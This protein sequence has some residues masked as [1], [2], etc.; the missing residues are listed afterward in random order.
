M[1]A[2]VSALIALSVRAGIAGAASAF[3]TKGLT[4][5]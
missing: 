4:A 3:G 5:N 1:E 2:I